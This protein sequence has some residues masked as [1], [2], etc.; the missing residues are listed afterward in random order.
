MFVLSRYN[1][2]TDAKKAAENENGIIHLLFSQQ[3][4]QKLRFR[5]RSLKHRSI[6]ARFDVI[7]TSL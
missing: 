2:K 4:I 7:L 6:Y 5:D 1:N 3:C